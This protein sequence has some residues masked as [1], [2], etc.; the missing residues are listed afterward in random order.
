MKKLALILVV[1][2]PLSFFAQS[3]KDI[4][5]VIQ[6]TLDLHAL[7]GYFNEDEK[8][9]QTPIIIIN[10]DK[11][12]NNLIVFKFNKRVKVMTFEEMEVFR[13]IYQGS[14]D[15]YF[16]FEIMDFT[17]TTVTIKATFRKNEKIAINVNM[18]KENETWMVTESK[19]G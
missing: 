10:D 2:L 13:S 11:I 3:A 4:N 7:K 15:S 17:E 14:L 8:A 16:V 9:G 18:K 6:K 5:T 12:P 19:A 1:F